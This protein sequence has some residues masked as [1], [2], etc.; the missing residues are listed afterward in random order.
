MPTQVLIQNIIKW[1]GWKEYEYH[2]RA[3]FWTTPTFYVVHM[4]MH[5]YHMHAST[6]DRGLFCMRFFWSMPQSAR[7]LVV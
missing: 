6:G 2:V 5:G 3:K 4:H 7:G 1:G